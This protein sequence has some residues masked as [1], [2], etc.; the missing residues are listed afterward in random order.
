MEEVTREQITESCWSI[1]PM[2]ERELL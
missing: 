2:H 1:N